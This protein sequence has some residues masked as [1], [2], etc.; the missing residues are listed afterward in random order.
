MN[1]RRF[2][3]IALLACALVFSATVYALSEKGYESLHRFSKVLHLIE[4][5]Y[6]DQI[7][8][9]NTI[10]GAIRGMLRS[11]DP[12]SAY[13]SPEVYKELKVDTSGRFDGVGIEVTIR[14]GWITVITP[15]MG[16]PAEKAGIQPGD[17]IVKIDGQPTENLDLARAVKLMRGRRGSRVILTIK[18]DDVKEPFDVSVVRQKINVPSVKMEVIDG[19][20][21]YISILSFQEDTTDSLRKAIKKLR[22]QDALQGLIIDLRRNPGGLLEEAVAVSDEL[23]KDGIIVTTESRGVEIDRHTAHTEGDEPDCP[24]IALVDGGSASASEIVAGA[25]Q[26]NERALIL[27]TP[28]FGKGSVQTVIELGDGS[29]LK[30][31]VARYFTPN[32]TSI[33][34]YGIIPD[35][36]LPAKIE[37]KDKEGEKEAKRPRRIREAD[38]A[39][40]LEA[41][42]VRRARSPA[43]NALV[44]RLKRSHIMERDA[45]LARQGKI[46]DYQKKVAIDFM[47]YMDTGEISPLGGEPRD[48]V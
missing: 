23:L 9:E 41:R 47:K 16:S 32:G 6:V 22:K 25:L 21:G 19:K 33:Q 34:A 11:L 7:D 42:E 12:H 31:T 29:A 37:K 45:E 43:L 30:L 8:E 24:I 36:E 26:D 5:N 48:D 2:S 39:G 46:K 3:I 44:K 15:I 14:D 28:T 40:H 10:M 38:L 1:I 20:Y 13:M 35:I 27:G 17:Q 4:D 18:R